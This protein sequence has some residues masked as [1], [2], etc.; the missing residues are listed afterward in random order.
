MRR[1]STITVP[2]DLA[3]PLEAYCS[4]QS[5]APSFTAIVQAALREF[6]ASRGYLAPTSPFRLTPAPRGSGRSDVS[7]E[8]DRYLADG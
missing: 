6:L 2:D 4:H 7:V 1:R 3:G 8:H 5:V